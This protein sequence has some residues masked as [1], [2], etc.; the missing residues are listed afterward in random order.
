MTTKTYSPQ[1]PALAEIMEQ[2]LSPEEK[3]KQWVKFIDEMKWCDGDDSDGVHCPA[4]ESLEAAV[5]RAKALGLT[6]STRTRKRKSV[7]VELCEH[8]RMCR[9]WKQP[10]EKHPD[11]AMEAVAEA[12][13]KIGLALGAPSQPL[14]DKPKLHYERR[15]EK[16]WHMDASGIWQGVSYGAV[17]R[18]VVASGM[19][20]RRERHG[21]LSEAETHLVEVMQN[22]AIDH[23][24]PLAGYPSGVQTFGDYK[25]LVTHGLK[26]IGPKEGDWKTINAIVNGMFGPKQKHYVYATLK[27]GYEAYRDESGNQVPMMTLCGPASG[28]GSQECAWKSAFAQCVIVPF[29]GG[30]AADASRYLTGGTE[31]NSELFGSETLL[32]DDILKRSNWTSR[33]D[34][35]ASLKNMLVG[36][37]QSLHGKGRDAIP[38]HPRWRVVMTNNDDRDSLRQMPEF[39]ENFKEKAHLFKINN[40]TLPMPNRTTEERKALDAQ[41]AKPMPAFIWSM[42]NWNVPVDIQSDR[43]GV[44][45]YHHPDLLDTLFEMSPEHRLAELIDLGLI[46]R[47]DGCWKGSS[48]QLKIDLCANHQTSKDADR[49]LNWADAAGH[50]LGRLRKREPDKYILNRVGKSRERVWTIYLTACDRLADAQDY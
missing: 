29:F 12:V 16:Y 24:G 10:N 19:S 9:H 1:S 33:H 39:A 7:A 40:F 36:C 45:T 20:D 5:E 47:S 30:R 18:L 23:A 22:D 32:L 50:L 3:A 2:L 49:L 38:L 15:S 4:E 11:W 43:F 48:T 46:R 41:V 21:G 17:S 42:L 28:D 37:H 26:L 6:T 44:R 14:I 27:Y 31:F 35:T 25:I 8:A 13:Q 34:L